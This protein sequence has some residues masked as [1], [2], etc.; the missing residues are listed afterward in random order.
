MKVLITAFLVTMSA[1]LYTDINEVRQA[2]KHANDT[3]ENAEQFYELTKAFGVNEGTIL[4]AYHGASLALKAS[5]AKQRRDKIAYFKQGKQ[6][7][8]AAIL[9][10]PNAIELRMIRLSVQ[11]N[12]PKIT[13]YHKNITADKK[14]ITDHVDTINSV[15][16]KTLV[17]GFMKDSKL[18]V[19]E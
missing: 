9:V 7:I 16:L 17:K 6:L 1:F 15:Q 3:E 19:I 14:F 12:A 8:D 2:F 13:R 4:S 11:S 18:F 5:K 10:K